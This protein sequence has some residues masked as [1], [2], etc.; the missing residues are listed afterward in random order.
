MNPHFSDA[1][2]RALGWALAHSLWMGA[3]LA[4]L[5]FL[6]FQKIQSPHYR[7]HSACAALLLFFCS[8][9]TAAW[10]AYEPKAVPQQLLYTNS[11]IHEISDEALI[12]AAPPAE[13]TLGEEVRNRLEHYSGYL[14]GIWMLGFCIGMIRLAGAYYYLHRLQRK[15]WDLAD[16][17]FQSRTQELSKRLALARPVRLMASALIHTPMTLGHLKPI[18]LLPI[19]LINQLSVAEVE[20]ILAH[21][22]AHIKR[23]DWLINLLQ[24]FM[25]ALFYYHPAV[26]WMSEQIRK[27]R[28]HCCDD[29]AIGLTENR[30]S[31]A[32]ALVQVQEMALN[33]AQPALALAIKGKQPL[34]HRKKPLLDRIKRVLNQSQPKSQVME[35]MIATGVLFLLLALYS[36]HNQTPKAL[37]QVFDA[38]SVTPAFW[39][40]EMPADSLPKPPKRIQHIIEEKDDKKVEIDLENGKLTRLQID[41]KEV[42]AIEY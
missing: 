40:T 11:I 25:E 18:I 24:A 13:F 38:L 37:A 33:G 27:E 20:A 6:V 2:I 34:L 39:E 12:S 32:K 31:Y 21:E 30:L 41:G 3:L 23:Q 5:L 26:W 8:V 4:F 15:G 35:K 14:V 19:G 29:I 10:L 9:G 17:V 42:P 7:Y 28:E 1:L 36:I 16:T 22:L